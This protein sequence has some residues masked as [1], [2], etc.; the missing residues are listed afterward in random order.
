[1]GIV[2]AMGHGVSVVAWRS[3]G[4]TSSIDS[5]VNGMLVEP[6]DED[7]FGRTINTLVCDPVQADRL[8][9]AA[10]LRVNDGL[11]YASHCQH[12]ASSLAAA[13]PHTKGRLQAGRAGDLDTSGQAIR[14]EVSRATP[15]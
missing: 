4:P 1:M 11:G 13:A 6:F 15:H 10:R 2:E 8:G 14:E 3:A 12:L 7:I 9:R 5:G